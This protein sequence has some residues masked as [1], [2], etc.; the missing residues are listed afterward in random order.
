MLYLEEGSYV[1]VNSEQLNN[2]C[3][4]VHL[5]YSISTD[6]SEYIISA[7]VAQFW[8]RFNIFRADFGKI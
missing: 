3:S 8:K 6:D 4:D 5:G 7:S 1:L 2:I